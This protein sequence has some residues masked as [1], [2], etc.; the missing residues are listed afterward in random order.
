MSKDSKLYVLL[1]SVFV[2]AFFVGVAHL[3]LLRFERGDVYPAYSS[4]RA[5]PLGSKA[6]CESLRR[7]P[8]ISV[9]RNY[10]PLSK[11]EDCRDTTVFYLGA[12]VSEIAR[13]FPIDLG[14][15]LELP[16]DSGRDL[17]GPPAGG[18]RLVISFYPTTGE[19][20]MT[21]REERKK[22][23]K[24][25]DEHQEKSAESDEKDAEQ[26]DTDDSAQKRP[27]SPSPTKR[28]GVGFGHA[29][30]PVSYEKP[31]GSAV[32]HRRD[33]DGIPDSVSWHTTLFFE[34]LDDA[35]R[36]VYARDG[37]PV[38]IEREFGAGTIVLSAD[39]Y[40]VS[41]EAMQHERNPGLLAWLVGPNTTVVFDETHL[42]VKEA[43]GIAV[44][45]RKY[46]LHGL[47]AGLVVLAGLFVW[48]NAVS[49]VPPYKDE[50]GEGE[51]EMAAGKDFTAGFANLLRRSIARKDIL[52][53]CLEEWKKCFVHGRTDPSRTLE[54][55][56]RV[57][58]EENA[59]AL[60]QRNTVR[61]YQT[62]SRMLAERKRV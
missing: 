52:N 20:W 50:V 29:E 17:D 28:W 51:G 61:C 24:L 58:A 18:G 40:H 6:F 35:W 19:S 13:G 53:V 46:R 56:E 11:L 47:F 5:D 14:D 9:R 4:L 10:Q 37:H 33:V 60:K 27:R 23:R 30:L 54:R 38:L 16:E 39:S 1:L 21:R 8:D 41:N 62:I 3:F 32:A 42:G 59:R 43:A 25:E 26:G 45:A 31:Y 15:L 2:V 44:L 7:L 34:D 49:L 12:S 22:G 55:M 48:K 57:I 36:V